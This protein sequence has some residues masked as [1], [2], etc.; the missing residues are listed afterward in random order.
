MSTSTTTEWGPAMILA[1]GMFAVATVLGLAKARSRFGLVGFAS[2]TGCVLFVTC[3]I[4]ATNGRIVLPPLI[5]LA[6]VEVAFRIDSLSRWFIGIIGLVGI[7]VCIYLPGYLDHLRGRVRPGLVWSGLA[8]LFGAMAGVVL[9][10]NAV[11]FIA[12]WEMMAISSF[13]LVATEHQKLSVR[14]AAFIYLGATRIGSAFLIAGFIWAHALTG[15]WRFEDWTFQGTSAT[16]PA[17]LILVGFLAKAGSWPFHLWLPIAHPA[18]P[19]PVSA[20]MSGVMIKTAIYGIVRLFLLGHLGAPW[21]GWI[22]LFLGCVSAV[23]GILFGLLQQDLK[24][25]L[26]YSSVENI[27]LLLLASGICLVSRSYGI[28]LASDLA[29]GAVLFHALNHSIFKS[30]LFLGAGSI[31][32]CAHTRDM[33]RLGGLA[34]RMPWT[35]AA[36]FVGCASICALAPLNGFAGEWLI[37]RSAFVVGYSAPSGELRLIGLILLGWVALTGGLTAACFLKAYGIVFLGNGRSGEARKAHEA[38]PGMVIAMCA[39]A[40]ACIGLGFGAPFVWQGLARM[41]LVSNPGGW[42]LPVFT[43]VL[44]G[45][46]LLAAAWAFLSRLERTH[47]PTV[48]STWDCGF[49]P[50]SARTQYSATSF[51]QPIVRLFGK[52]YRYEIDVV[53][54]GESQHN[55]PTTLSAELKHESYLESRVYSPAI[56]GMLRLSEGLIMRL[57]AGSIH[58]YLLFMIVTLALLLWLGGVI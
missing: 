55:F 43:T 5:G 39:L 28:A 20:V 18:A 50:L 16:L 58:Q 9:A 47:R 23:W 14:R 17:A 34:R 12:S 52:L 46:I 10:D 19:S 3:A 22:L 32:A 11:V 51:G 53:G 26:A 40:C 33:D 6:G 42:N 8:V 31:D 36:F 7:P 25:L 37:Y 2:L 30:L 21:V 4:F 44:G 38:A 54:K 56:K 13:L 57:Q 35:A 15:S 24:R 29:L 48:Y 49:G 1:L 27:G 45:G 41:S